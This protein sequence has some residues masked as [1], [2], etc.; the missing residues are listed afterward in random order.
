[1]SRRSFL[2]MSAT[3]PWALR[4]RAAGKIPV[5]LEMYSVRDEKQDADATVKAVAKMGYEGLEF[6]GP[7]FDWSE[8]R[9]KAIRKLLDDLGI[10]CFS[11]H[12]DQSNF[13][14]DKISR[15]RDLNLVL[16]A[17]YVVLSSSSEK[18][19]L[20]EWKTLADSLNASADQLE[21]SGLKVG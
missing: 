5:G 15:M 21:P 18:H 16:G 12:N 2:A 8:A 14:A 10:R 13:S 9:A 11:T 6:Y 17:K 3:L 19:K 7:Y 20:D 4:A 1:I